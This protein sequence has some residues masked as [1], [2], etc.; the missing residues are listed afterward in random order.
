MFKLKLT[1]SQQSPISTALMKRHLENIV[2]K[3]E[4]A[5]NQ[6]FLLFLAMFITLSKADTK[7]VCTFNFSS[8]DTFNLV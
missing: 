1:L 2:R 4:N 7:I 8:A 6:D 3:R 5:S